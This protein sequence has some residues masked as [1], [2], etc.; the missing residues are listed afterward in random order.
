GDVEHA[1][2]APDHV[3]LLDLR[4]VVDRHVPAGEID[5]AR[6]CSEVGGMK[7]GLSGG[8]RHGGQVCPGLVNEKGAGLVLD[9]SCPVC[10]LYLRDF[11]CHRIRIHT[12]SQTSAPSVDA[13][14]LAW[15]A[16]L[17]RFVIRAR[18]ICLSGSG[19]CAFGGSQELSPARRRDNSI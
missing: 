19:C 7:G 2:V 3:V 18:S 8:T 9:Q 16:S 13:H 1:R 5:H 11:V 17:S 6:A 10:P 15:Y 14:T 4:A 12:G